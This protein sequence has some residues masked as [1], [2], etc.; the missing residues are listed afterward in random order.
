M[1]AIIP[2]SALSPFAYAASVLPTGATIVRHRKGK[3][4]TNDGELAIGTRM[5]VHDISFGWIKFN[6]PGNPP[7]RLVASP[8]HPQPDRVELGDLDP[9]LWKIGLDGQPSDPWTEYAEATTTKLDNGAEFQISATSS[10]ARRALG[11]LAKKIVWGQQTRGA[12]AVPVIELRS[13]EVRGQFSYDIP[14]YPIVDWIGG[15]DSNVEAL[16]STSRSVRDE[17]DDTVPF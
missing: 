8:A 10:T 1:N 12:Q 2:T 11:Q 13:R 15:N 4:V 17:I 9:G 5:A 6:G 7:D 3:F 16:P 14:E